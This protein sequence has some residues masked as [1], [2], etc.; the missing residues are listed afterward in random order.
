[1]RMYESGLCAS[2]LSLKRRHSMTGRPYAEGQSAVQYLASRIGRIN[3]EVVHL[4][5]EAVEHRVVTARDVPGRVCLWCK[6]ADVKCRE[7][8][9]I[10][11]RLAVT[12]ARR[13]AVVFWE[14]ALRELVDD[15]RLAVCGLVQICTADLARQ[16]CV[17]RPTAKDTEL[18]AAADRVS[19]AFCKLDAAMRDDARARV[20]GSRKRAQG[21]YE[22]DNKQQDQHD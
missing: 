22:I 8:W 17:A 21:G 12:M 11:R 1:M 7:R 18:P 16:A 4:A 6:R 15:G 5:V 14:Y 3:R 20:C 9:H 19:K 2:A 13:Y 10:H